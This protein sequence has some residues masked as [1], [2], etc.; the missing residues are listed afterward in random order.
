MHLLKEKKKNQVFPKNTVK[1]QC[2]AQGKTKRKPEKG[3]PE[4][5]VHVCV[6]VYLC[7]HNPTPGDSQACNYTLVGVK[8]IKASWGEQGEE[9]CAVKADNAHPYQTAGFS[10]TPLGFIIIIFPS[11]GVIIRDPPTHPRTPLGNIRATQ[12]TAHLGW[13]Q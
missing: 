11:F 8:L 4:R 3:G 6:C 5:M 13:P 7:V 9:R 2:S 12:P 10:I 1:F